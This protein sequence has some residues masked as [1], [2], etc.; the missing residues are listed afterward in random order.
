[1][2]FNIYKFTNPKEP[3]H[4]LRGVYY[5]NGNLVASDGCILAV[6]KNE[7]PAEYEGRI[8]DKAGKDIKLK[9]NNYRCVIPI[10]EDWPTYK[11][12]FAQVREI[13]KRSKAWAKANGKKQ[14]CKERLIKVGPA[15]F[16]LDLFEV[17]I[18]G[19]GHIG[20]NILMIKNA[21]IQAVCKND[22]G[23]FIIM[24]H[25][26]PS[27]KEGVFIEELID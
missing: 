11:I 27:D 20:N 24:P 15:F 4:Q 6:I 10:A 18:S 1:M 22:K 9:Y 14:N 2:K 5:D 16:S 23:I 26:E 7:Y 19:M 17:L 13:I 25:C 3:R 8:I 12:D 21:I